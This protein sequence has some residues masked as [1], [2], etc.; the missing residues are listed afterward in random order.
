M[1]RGVNRVS[2]PSTRISRRS[3]NTSASPIF[4]MFR[5]YADCWSHDA[6]SAISSLSSLRCSPVICVVGKATRSRRE[7][8]GKATAEGIWEIPGTCRTESGR[9]TITLRAGVVRRSL[10][11]RVH[12]LRPRQLALGSEKSANGLPVG[13]H[14]PAQGQAPATTHGCDGSLLP[15]CSMA[16]VPAHLTA[17]GTQASSLPIAAVTGNSRIAR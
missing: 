14:G 16:G 17:A 15:Q 2:T 3:G 7:G 11:G 9:V 6:L 13:L 12:D 10:P 8:P 4:S 5:G 1:L